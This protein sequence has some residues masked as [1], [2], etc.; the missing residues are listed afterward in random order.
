MRVGVV[1]WASRTGNGQINRDLWDIGFAQAWLVPEHPLLG[2]EEHLCPPEAMRCRVEGDDE[3]YRTFL[4][5]IDALVFIE[6]PYLMHFDLVG[7]ARKRG[8]L[9]C[10]VPMMEWLPYEQWAVD[11]DVMWAPTQYSLGDLSAFAVEVRAKGGKCRWE[12]DGRIGGRWG[13]RVDQFPYRQRGTVERFLFCNGH[14]GALGRKG[15]LCVAAASRLAPEIPILFRT[16]RDMDLPVMSRSVELLYDNAP[17]KWNIYD[18]G[19][20]LLAPS[21]FEGLGHQHYE[22]Q[23]CGLPVITTNAPPMDECRPIASLPATRSEASLCGRPFA[24]WDAVPETLAQVMHAFHG[25]D[26]SRNSRDGREFIETERNLSVIAA[27]LRR[28]L[29]FRKK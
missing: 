19:D 15:A 21:R 16:Q 12:A 13:V 29:E 3:I 25:T 4:D 1:G 17:E 22:A 28:D 7:E 14:G 6:R 24:V 11:V 20:V 8:V 27:D 23:A 5:S 26:V 10:C 9:T 2:I 18:R